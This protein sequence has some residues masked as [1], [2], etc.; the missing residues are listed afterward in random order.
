MD[1]VEKLKELKNLLDGGFLTQ[2]EANKMKDEIL[3]NYEKPIPHPIIDPSKYVKIAKQIWMRENLN[4][5]N[6]KN[7]DKIPEIKSDEEWLK[8][9]HEKKPAWCYYNND[10][11]M[12]EKYGK[13]YNWYA[14]NDSRGIA[15]KGW[16]IPSAT[17]F[18]TLFLSVGEKAEAKLK[19]LGAGH[20]RY[21]EGTNES[22][23]T[24]LS[25]GL[26]HCT[27]EQGVHYAKDLIFYFLGTAGEIW[28]S[29]E[30]TDDC[31][32]TY[33]F[34]SAGEGFAIKG[35]GH[36]IRCIWDYAAIL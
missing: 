29:T 8:C 34:L 18:N 10:P 30:I 12:G 13:L 4:V 22:G 15:P 31:A 19:P 14:V 36:Y 3:L 26:R 11:E 5:S 23:F 21:N 1:K 20:G 24:W 7:G 17:E 6:F 25:G 2:D 33:C 9:H 27:Y 16:H 32:R 28:S 35:R